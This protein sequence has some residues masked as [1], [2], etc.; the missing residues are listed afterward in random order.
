M[1]RMVG[2]QVWERLPP[3]T[4]A[5]RRAEGPA[6]VTDIL[7]VQRE[8]AF[9]P[10]D[11]RVPVVLGRGGNARPQHVEGAA[12]LAAE[13]PDVDRFVIEGGG[14]GSHLSHPDDFAR[15]VRAVLRRASAAS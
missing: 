4:K 5:A 9:R 1:R 3:S 6:L 11:V 14:H 15:F 7:S 13:L 2:D 12:R 8:A 10:E